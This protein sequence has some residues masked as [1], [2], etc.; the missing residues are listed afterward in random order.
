MNSLRFQIIEP[1]ERELQDIFDYYEA[2]TERLGHRF[3]AEFRRAV[4]RIRQFPFAWPQLQ[5]NVRKCILKRFPFHVIYAVTNELIIILA[6]AH[7]RRKPDYWI[8]RIKQ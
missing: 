7:H 4:Q 3:I 5:G 8:D 6:I 2:E 1:A